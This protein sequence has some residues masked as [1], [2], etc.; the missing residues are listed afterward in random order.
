MD[1]FLGRFPM[2]DDPKQKDF[3]VTTKLI[4]KD[5]QQKLAAKRKGSPVPPVS[6]TEKTTLHVSDPSSGQ[7]TQPGESTG[8]LSEPTMPAA[9]AGPPPGGAGTIDPLPAPDHDRKSAGDVSVLV[10]DRLEKLERHFRRQMWF[11]RAILGMLGVLLAFQ[12]IVLVQNQPLD[13]RN[14]E[15]KPRPLAPGPEGTFGPTLQNQDQQVQPEL[16]LQSNADPKL[17]VIDKPVLPKSPDSQAEAISQE[18]H[19]VAKVVYVGSKTSNKYHYPTCKWVKQI[20]PGRLIT[21]KSVEDARNR[22]YIP[23]PA[24]KPPPL[25]K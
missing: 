16:K 3:E 11:I 5:W 20:K 13:L 8:A 2:S 24:C 4:V 7:A 9:A 17:K 6:E 18:R 15:S 12:V 23:C 21:F 25:A 10:F 22:R 1:Y 19:S 14:L